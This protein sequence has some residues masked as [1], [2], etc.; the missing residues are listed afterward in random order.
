MRTSYFD[1]GT[2][3]LEYNPFTHTWSLGVEEQVRP[4]VVRT[5][6]VPPASAALCV[7]P[8]TADCHHK[9]LSPLLQAPHSLSMPSLGHNNYRSR[10]PMLL[11]PRLLTTDRMN[12]YVCVA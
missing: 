11:P 6:G 10:L 7:A 1:A 3:A 12:V 4:P 5:N 8:I 2:A 9:Q